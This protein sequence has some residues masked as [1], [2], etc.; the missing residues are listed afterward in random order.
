MLA[1]SHKDR[2]ECWLGIGATSLIKEVGQ[3]NRRKA[4]YHQNPAE[5]EEP[6]DVEGELGDLRCSQSNSQPTK[7]GFTAFNQPST[8]NF[9]RKILDFFQ[10]CWPRIWARKLSAWHLIRADLYWPSAWS[11]KRGCWISRRRPTTHAQ[12]LAFQ[13]QMSSTSPPWTP[14]QVC[15][16]QFMRNRLG[17]L[18][19]FPGM[20][21][22]FLRFVSNVGS[23]DNLLLSVT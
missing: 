2:V 17:N 5:N 16:F 22:G 9:D 23:V 6:R 11:S 10:S 20:S 13:F 3:Q 15:N 7:P 1:L 21:E 4:S 8:S 14:G 18:I 12:I 19:F